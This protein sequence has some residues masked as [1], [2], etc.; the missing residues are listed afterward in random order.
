MTMDTI[1]VTPSTSSV[2]AGGTLSAIARFY[3]GGS[4]GTPVT[5]D[6]VQF[7][8]D[9]ATTGTQVRG[10]TPAVPATSSAIFL[11]S[12]DT[13]LTHPTD[14]RE[15][16]TITFKATQGATTLQQTATFVV[17]APARRA[18]LGYPVTMRNFSWLEMVNREW[19]S[20]YRAPDH[21]IY[22]FSNGRGFDST[23]IG[24][25]GIYRRR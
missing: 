7:R 9:C 19:G 3:S 16:F 10:W 4:G 21:R 11:D 2:A 22:Q 17:V 6:T 1:T 20:E 14:S 24:E 23:D 12:D 8:I 18:N 25:T 15:T 5:P 13:Q